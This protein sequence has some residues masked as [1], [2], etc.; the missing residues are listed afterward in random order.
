MLPFSSGNAV[1]RMMIVAMI[2]GYGLTFIAISVLIL[3]TYV[4][5]ELRLI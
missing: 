3:L 4:L 5:Y 2:G 1:A